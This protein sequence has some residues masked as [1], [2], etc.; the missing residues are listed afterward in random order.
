[1]LIGP[2]AVVGGVRACGGVLG[3]KGHS[4]KKKKTNEFLKEAYARCMNVNVSIYSF[5]GFVFLGLANRSLHWPD[6]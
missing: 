1:M 4:N 6:H 3:K 2:G 5:F